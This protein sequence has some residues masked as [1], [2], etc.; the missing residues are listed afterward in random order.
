MTARALELGAHDDAPVA[1]LQLVVLD[2]HGPHAETLRA[3]LRFADATGRDVRIVATLDEA[4][5]I[6]ADA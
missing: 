6:L 4:R 5:A 3:Y 1:T 2:V